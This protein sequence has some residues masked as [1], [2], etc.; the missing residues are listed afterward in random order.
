[1]ECSQEGFESAKC[2]CR[3]GAAMCR[4]ARFGTGTGPN[5]TADSRPWATRLAAAEAINRQTP[6]VRRVRAS[7]SIACSIPS[8]SL[9]ATRHCLTRAEHHI[10]F[11]FAKLVKFNPRPYRRAIA[12][13][14]IVSNV[15]R[16]CSLGLVRAIKLTQGSTSLGCKAGAECLP[17]YTENPLPLAS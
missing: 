11:L 10:R 15:T 9:N 5:V 3:I 12:G 16:S 13:S 1:M 6:R 8:A 17:E 2:D 7:T 4:T 14:E